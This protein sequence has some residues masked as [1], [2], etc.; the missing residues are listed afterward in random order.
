MLLC[1]ARGQP[2]EMLQKGD[3]VDQIGRGNILPSAEAALE[4]AR[5]IYEAKSRDSALRN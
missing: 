4:R 5:E 2:A 3:V 1:G